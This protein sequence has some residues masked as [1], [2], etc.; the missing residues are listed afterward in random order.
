MVILSTV[1]VLPRDFLAVLLLYSLKKPVCW[2]LLHLQIFY[3]IR[4]EAVAEIKAGRR[5][6]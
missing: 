2:S 6:W 3:E 4:V 1:D 5:V